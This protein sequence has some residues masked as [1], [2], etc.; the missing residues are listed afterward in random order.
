[1]RCGRAQ[2][3][4]TAAVD[5]EL[6][7][8]HRRALDRHLAGCETCRAELGTTERMLRAL[9]ALPM[10]AEV[11]DRLEAATLRQVRLLAAEAEERET[12]AWW[13]RWRPL[14]AFAAVAV[15]VLLLAVGIGRRTGQ[16]PVARSVSPPSQKIARATPQAPPTPAPRAEAPKS[17][18]PP[19][20]PPP[21]LAAAP[22]LFMEL[23]ILR[24]MEKLEHFDAIRTTTLDDEAPN[25]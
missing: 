8:R 19:P 18:P 15:A 24:N 9:D 5:G 21:E 22:D 1:M 4:M 16:M 3:F 14:P 7:P 2:M 10:E 12:T 17:T 6:V 25:G 13:R 23:P 20:E 11:P